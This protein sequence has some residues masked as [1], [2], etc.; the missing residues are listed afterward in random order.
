M[1]VS[2]VKPWR[3]A[4][5]ELRCLPSLLRGPVLRSAFRRLAWNCLGDVMTRPSELGSFRNSAAAAVVVAGRMID[6]LPLEQGRAPRY[7][8]RILEAGTGWVVVHN[9]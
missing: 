6:R 8:R 1:T 7:S 5:R 2:A 9:L 3:R 4:L